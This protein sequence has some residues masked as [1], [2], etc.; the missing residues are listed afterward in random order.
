[1]PEYRRPW[2]PGAT[3]FVTIATHQRRKR[4]VDDAT[5]QL[6][7]EAIARAMQAKPF[8]VI[9]AVILPDHIHLIIELPPGMVDLSIRIGLAKALFTKSLVAPPSASPSRRRRHESD[10][11]QRRFY[12]HMIRDENDFIA[13]MD[14][15]HYNPVRHGCVKCPKDW[16]WSSFRNWA[17]R[18]AY[19]MDWG[20]PGLGAAP[21]FKS[22]EHT[23]GE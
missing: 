14:Y 4:F 12:D 18:G 8:K 6:W 15:V 10:V 22:I 16:P 21:D 20:C 1:M 19:P 9:A 13:H 7:R 3:Y 2:V 5:V 23:L 17:M 11:W